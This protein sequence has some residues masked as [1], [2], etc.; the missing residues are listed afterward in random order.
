MPFSTNAEELLVIDPGVDSVRQL[1]DGRRPG[2]EVLYLT[3]HGDAFGQI[4]RH[5]E[6]RRD[7]AT[8]HILSHGEPGILLLAGEAIDRAAVAAQHGALA[9][10]AEALASNAAVL[11]Y[12]CSVAAGPVGQRFVD[13]L[14]AV[15]GVTVAASLGPVGS[16]ALGG[17]WSL[18][19]R[20]G[21]AHDLA[22]TPEAQAAYAAVLVGVPTLTT[23]NDAPILSAGDNTLEAAAN[24]LNAGDVINGLAGTDTLQ[25]T[26]VQNV[27]FGATT[28]T[29]FEAIT[30]TAGVQSITTHDATVGAGQTLSVDASASTSGVVWKG[31]AELDGT[32]LINGST[33]S[34]TLS[35]GAGNDT[36]YGGAGNDIL[37]G[38]AG[39]DTA[40]GGAGDD[41]LYGDDG[42]D[43]LY[44]Q[45]GNDSLYGGAGNDGLSGG[46]G[47]DSLWGGDG[48]DTLMASDGDDVLSGEAGNDWMWG[49]NGNDTL[50]GGA[51]DDT[52]SGD[53]G[54]DVLYGGDDNDTISGGADN[55][56]LYGEAGDDVLVGGAGTDTLSGGAGNDT[57]KGSATDL[58]G[59]TIAD[60]AIGDT[61]TVTGADLSDLNGATASGTITLGVGQTLTLTGISTAS[62]TFAAT[63][64]GGTTTIT[65]VAPAGGDGGGGGGGESA[66]PAPAPTEDGA[67]VSRT[68]TTGPTGQ[69]Q[70]TTVIQPVPAGR[71]DDPTTPSADRADVTLVTDAGS[72]TPALRASLPTGFGLRVE[73]A[74]TRQNKTDALADLIA[75]IEQKTTEG[76]SQRTEMT[77]IGQSFLN[78]L[79]ADSQLIVKTVTPSVATGSGAPGTPLVITGEQATGHQSAL[80]IDTSGLPSGTMLQLN[81]VDFAAIIGAA[82]ITGG[83]GRNVVTGDDAA[84][85]IVLG[86]E[87]DVLRG[88]AGDDTIGSEG[89]RDI[90][91]GD[92]GNDTVF[93]GDGQDF[94]VGGTGDDILRG[95]NGM[96][97]VFFSGTHVSHTITRGGDRTLTVTDRTFVNGTDQLS[98]VEVLVFSDR[99]DLAA[100]PDLT[101]AGFDEGAYLAAN[102]DVA[103]A[104]QGGSFATGLQHFR[105]HGESENRSPNALFDGEWYLTHNADVATAVAAEQMTAWQHYSQWG[106]KE[107][108]DTGPFFDQSRY[109]EE[110]ADVAAASD[111]DPL[112]HFL[113]W[114]WGEG[115]A[116]YQADTTAFG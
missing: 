81:G 29:N 107:G 103:A 46:D 47:N 75:R 112:S 15:L 25:I 116:A 93:G 9:T 94:L 74:S 41:S 30:I 68:T 26:G 8:L 91:H 54:D 45:D 65:L 98:T 36:L 89:G 19:A 80:V 57:F 12:G 62:G 42:N 16:S 24:A 108:R 38:G 63:L 1:T 21:L 106:W 37:S 31:G 71:T 73:G 50:Y 99:V 49:Q 88:G 77:G 3:P 70:Q 32:F 113:Q 13:D 95:D 10:I 43:F 64:A 27:T 78:A 2:L 53:A 14:E 22:F 58:N 115:R 44:G 111:L 60:F 40:F 17:G 100:A 105:L 59:D 28:L 96:D 55:D 109:L 92:A 66:A 23:G 97:A 56:I 110:N 67:T 102:A 11:L 84:Q 72:T 76:S 52:L 20:Q 114:G 90:L 79:S 101:A 39:N 4:A 35:G 82:H 51:G 83:A 18:H 87:D 69:P 61:I 7:V 6:G 104:V 48:N 33:V 34:D 5:L 86:A 85:Y